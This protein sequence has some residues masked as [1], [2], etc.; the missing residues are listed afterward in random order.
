MFSTLFNIRNAFV[1]AALVASL[2]SCSSNNAPQNEKPESEKVEQP[3]EEEGIHFSPEELK[4]AGIVTQEVSSKAVQDQLIL[5]ANIAANQDR[6]AHVTPR[7]EG[8]LAKVLVNLGDMVKAGQPLAEIDSI[9]MGEARAQYRSSQSELA[10]AQANFDRI[11]RLFEEK[12]VAQKQWLETK[13]IYERAKSNA[14]AD[15]E[16]LRMYGGLNTP[17]GSTYVLAAPFKGLILEKNAVIGELAKPA[18]VIFTVGDISTVWIEADVPEGNLKDLAVGKTANVTVTAYPNDI[19]AGRV[20]YIAN[21]LD[22]ATRT[23]KARIEIPN[24]DGRL[25]I[26]MFAKVALNLSTSS[27]VILVPTNSVTLVQGINN[28]YVEK[29]ESFEARPVE[30]GNRFND[31]IEIKAGLE[32]GEKV[33]TAGV[34]AL[35]A[36]QLKSQISDAH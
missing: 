2:V 21:M 20:S 33:V 3:K 29:G 36:R 25:R 16:R 28:V 22:K 11:N 31:S 30:I 4:R 9:P 1:Y 26:D 13:S 6:L 35:K 8:K 32:I 27:K 18:D 5:T 24:P 7:I 15:S 10:L 17:N 19:F 34:Y 12:V 23:V 14:Q